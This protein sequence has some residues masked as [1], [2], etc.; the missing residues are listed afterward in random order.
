[1]TVSKFIDRAG[2]P[3]ELVLYMFASCPYCQ[4][5]LRHAEELGFNLQQRDIRLDKT[6]WATLLREGGKTTVPC[7]FIDGKA[8][9]ESADIMRYLS[10]DVR[11]VEG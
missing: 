10:N 3:V 5:V 9:Y 2:H 8:M 1:M 7:L 6:A 4:K 11:R